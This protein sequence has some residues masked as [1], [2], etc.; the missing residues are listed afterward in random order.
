MPACMG[1]AA[2]SN[3]MS[4]LS[5]HISWAPGFLPPSYSSSPSFFVYCSK[6]KEENAANKDKSIK[7]QKLL[8]PQFNKNNSPGRYF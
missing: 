3:P 2:W 5:K 1:A 7:V 4:S 6:L 8:M